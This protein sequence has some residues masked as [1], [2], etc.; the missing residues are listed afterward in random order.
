MLLSVFVLLSYKSNGGLQLSV[1]LTAVRTNHWKTTLARSALA[2]AL[3]CTAESQRRPRWCML[4][5][6]AVGYMGI[7]LRCRR[8][9]LT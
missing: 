7:M 5:E 6:D 9:R 8:I 1:S 4:K 3:A 2:L